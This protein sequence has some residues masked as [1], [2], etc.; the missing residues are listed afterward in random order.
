MFDYFLNK[1][2]K[3]PTLSLNKSVNDEDDFYVNKIFF[4]KSPIL[5]LPINIEEFKNTHKS[6]FWYNI[7]RA[8]RLLKEDF[9]D[10]KI[11]IFH[12]EETIKKN[13]HKVYDLFNLRWK[14][15]YTSFS[16]KTKSGFKNYSD[17]IIDL[18]KT[19]QG[20]ISLIEANNNPV[21]FTYCLL[22]NEKIYLFQAAINPEKI[23]SRYDLGK[24]LLKRNI[25]FGIEKKLKIFDFGIGVSNYKSIWSNRELKVYKLI[26]TK[27]GF[28]KIFFHYL[29][30]IKFQIKFK[31]QNNRKI[32]NFLKKFLR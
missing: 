10:I 11:N 4:T 15:E 22:D 12:N 23:Y 9:N 6:K 8:E 32:V 14:D 28:F 1:Y 19:D 24:I 26:K 31:I 25:E 7:R 5:D 3:N 13:I 2:N 20:M 27:K 29:K 30:I 21:A 16:W 18:A 17:A